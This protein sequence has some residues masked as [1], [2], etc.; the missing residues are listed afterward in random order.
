MAT[1]SP[2]DAAALRLMKPPARLRV[3]LA[4]RAPM[5]PPAGVNIGASVA[6]GQILAAAPAEGGPA[7]LAPA[8]GKIVGVVDV[9]LTNGQVVPAVEL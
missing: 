3:P 5:A 9:M 8:S 7:A 6:R 2:V 4:T 1:P